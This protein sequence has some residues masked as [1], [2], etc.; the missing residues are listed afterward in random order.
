MK[1]KYSV[2]YYNKIRKKQRTLFY[3]E[4][5]ERVTFVPVVHSVDTRW[6]I[7]SFWQ[8]I[9]TFPMIQRLHKFSCF[10]DRLSLIFRWEFD[11]ELYIKNYVMFFFIYPL[12]CLLL[13]TSS[14]Y[15]TFWCK[16]KAKKCFDLESDQTEKKRNYEAETTSSVLPT[17]DRVLLFLN[18][19]YHQSL[20]KLKDLKMGLE[21]T[22]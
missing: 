12:A 7:S 6:S 10:Y 1:C 3:S 5:D 17:Q 14:F 2:K 18:W 22:K 19:I 16:R 21:I 9:M 15:G 8:N 11:S 4:N 20:K 13:L